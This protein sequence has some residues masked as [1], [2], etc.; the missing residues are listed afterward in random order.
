[1]CGTAT[2]EV[3]QEERDL[4][5]HPPVGRRGAFVKVTAE[6]HAPAHARPHEREGRQVWREPNDAVHAQAPRKPL[7]ILLERPAHARDAPDAG[8]V[9]FELVP[10]IRE[11]ASSGDVLEDP[12]I[13][14]RQLGRQRPL[15]V[16]AISPSDAGRS[17][18][19]PIGGAIGRSIAGSNDSPRKSHTARMMRSGS[20]SRSSYRTSM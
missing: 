7:G 10:E 16:R 13:R 5:A 2:R 14:H 6:P 20:A 4:H 3:R 15:L 19:P 9:P 11:H 18:D 17:R 8:I 12:P 1:M